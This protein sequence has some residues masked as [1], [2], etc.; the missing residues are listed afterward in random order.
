MAYSPFSRSTNNSPSLFIHLLALSARNSTTMLFWNRPVQASRTTEQ[1]VQVSEPTEQQSKSVKLAN[2]QNKKHN[3]A[4]TW[5]NKQS[6]LC[7]Q[8]RLRSAWAS[9]QSDQSLRCTHEVTLGPQLPIECT[10]KTLIR[11]DGCQGWSETSLGAQIIL[12]VLSRGGSYLIG[13]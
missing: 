11:M 10:A 9:V 7:A 2:K 13:K 6:D 5:Q 12:L 3:W 4:A 8:R 1:I